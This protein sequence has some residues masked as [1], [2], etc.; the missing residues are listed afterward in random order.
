MSEKN[1]EQ[2]P[3]NLGEDLLGTI[4]KITIDLTR[5]REDWIKPEGQA[6]LLGK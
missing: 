4:G 2:Q 6:D 5:K 1:P 3:E